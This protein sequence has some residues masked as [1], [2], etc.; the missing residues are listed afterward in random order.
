[1]K[2]VQSKSNS[3][4]TRGDPRSAETKAGLIEAAVELFGL[5][6]YDSTSTRA[7][8]AFAGT[9]LSA[10]PYHFKTKKALFL[11]AAESIA[12]AIS[13][14]LGPVLDAFE[15][16]IYS[17]NL[18]RKRAISLLTE[19]FAPFAMMLANEE[20]EKWA[21]FTLREQ[22]TPSEAFNILFA[23]DI[24]RFFNVV[25]H[26]TAIATNDVPSSP[27]SKVRGM[28]LI[29]QALAFRAAR[30]LSLKMMEKDKFSASDLTIIS[31]TIKENIRLF[32]YV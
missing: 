24:G 31:A 7:I 23:S 21:R 6:G 10:I 14:R 18:T 26:L 15:D 16:E 19:V 4:S 5:Y 2:T 29:G 3:K 25:C 22:A 32:E 12:D 8:A 1:M 27:K 11:A 13:V 30:A 17:D 9:A 28:T 20:S